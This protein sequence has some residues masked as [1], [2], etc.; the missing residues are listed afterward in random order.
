MIF[1]VEC[2]GAGGIFRMQERIVKIGGEG[3]HTGRK[4]TNIGTA[5]IRIYF[6]IEMQAKVPDQQSNF[7]QEKKKFGHKSLKEKQKMMNLR[8]ILISG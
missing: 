5:C 7:S 2:E 8:V 6:S 1:T 4:S 3:N